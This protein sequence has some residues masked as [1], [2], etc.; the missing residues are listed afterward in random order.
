MAIAE[1]DLDDEARAARAAVPEA[2]RPD[3][4]RIVSSNGLKLAVYEWG[5]VNAPPILLTHGG[6]D[7]AGTWDLFA[8]LLADGGWRVVAWDQR[9]HGDSEHAALYSW[10]ADVRDAIAVMDTLS[11][12]ALPVLG[13]SKG[14]GLLMQLGEM[15]PHRVSHLVNVDGLPGKGRRMVDVPEHE[16]SRMMASELT[17]WLEHRRSS[18][19]GQRKPGTL[20]ELAGRRARMNPRLSREWLRYLVTI[21]ARKDADG[22]RWRIDPSM[23]F[24]GFGP[25][26]PDWSL[27]RMPGLGMPFLGILGLHMEEMGWGVKPADV[28]PY[29]PMG[30]EFHALDTG[31]FVHIEQPRAV[32]DI[33]LDFL[34]RR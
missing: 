4:R 34:A 13:H 27:L 33:V 2:R 10:D 9:G 26:R 6:M 11:S 1:E 3:R 5:D 21:G 17:R 20:D 22:W 16:R 28:E 31:H 25:W 19:T 29:L 12:G 18:A 8:P 30:A 32:A 15:A 14:G 23:R 7:F 24:G